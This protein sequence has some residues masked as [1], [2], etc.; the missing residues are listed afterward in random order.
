MKAISCVL[1]ANCI[2]KVDWSLLKINSSCSGFTPDPHMFQCIQTAMLCTIRSS[3]TPSSMK[4]RHW[5]RRQRF[6]LRQ[7]NSD[8]SHCQKSGLCWKTERKQRISSQTMFQSF[9]ILWINTSR[10]DSRSSKEIMLERVT[11]AQARVYFF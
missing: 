3:C 6:R 9:G 5:I 11:L 2:R 4:T 7:E 8:G 10:E 1:F